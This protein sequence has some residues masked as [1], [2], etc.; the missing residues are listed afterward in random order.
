MVALVALLSLLLLLLLALETSSKSECLESMAANISRMYSICTT[1]R[2]ECGDSAV[3][4][5]VPRNQNVCQQQ[6]HRDRGHRQQHDRK[7][8]SEERVETD[9]IALLLGKTTCNYIG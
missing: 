6:V 7:S 3:V 8:H 9:R 1:S 4:C 2:C 5:L